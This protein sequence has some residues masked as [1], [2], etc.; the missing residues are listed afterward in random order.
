MSEL[1]NNLEKLRDE[2]RSHRYP[3]SLAADLARRPA[4]AVRRVT[5]GRIAAAASVITALAATVAIWMS[6][7]PAVTPVGPAQTPGGESAVAV[8]EMHDLGAM[9]A[10]PDELPLVPAEAQAISEA[11]P[12]LS[13]LG[14]MPEMPS[15]NL[16]LSYGDDTETPEDSV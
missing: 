15:M 9:P 5:F 2:Y 4:Q 14:S 3:G 10:M 12:S 11:A 8:V 13:D 6:I 7:E 16:D 1:R